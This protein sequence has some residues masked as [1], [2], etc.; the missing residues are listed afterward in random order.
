MRAVIVYWAWPQAGAGH[1]VRAAAITRWL[2]SDVLVIRGTDNVDINR[3]LD[4]FDIPYVA[5]KSRAQAIEVV[6][7]ITPKTLVVDDRASGPLVPMADM[8]IW[9]LGRPTVSKSTKPMVKTEGPGS[10]FPVVM[11]DESEILSREEAREDL[12]LDQEAFIRAGV[13]ST[14]RPGV[15]EAYG[16]DI[17]LD[18]WPALKW[19]RAADHI[20]G[21]IGA[22]LYA[23]VQYLGLPA[24]WIKAPA[25]KDQAVR[26]YNPPKASIIPD[27]A[28]RIAAMIEEINVRS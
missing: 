8:F 18:R 3:S 27:A 16:P 14:D 1:A 4:Y 26:I 9:R 19:M 21:C 2:T 7:A 6:R 20:V 12:G 15:V 13:R 11:L 22:N 28:K 23:E 24:T 25:V 5:I 10:M 17:M